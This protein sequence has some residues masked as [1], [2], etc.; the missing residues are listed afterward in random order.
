[1]G[2]R[3]DILSDLHIEFNGWKPFEERL[4]STGSKT[5][6][7]S[8]DLGPI[9]MTDTSYVFSYLSRIYDQI[10]YV[11]GN[12]DYYG[13]SISEGNTLLDE[14][15]DW[16]PGLEI[17]RPGKVSLIGNYKV[18]G[19]TLW[20]PFHSKMKEYPI[21]DPYQITDLY[22]YLDR[23]YK[24]TVKW[25]EETVDNQTI[26][27][28]HHLPHP[29]SVAAQYKGEQTNAWFVSD[30]SGLIED[31]KPFMWIHGH[32]HCKVDYMVGNTRII[33]NAYGYPSENRLDKFG[34]LTY[35]L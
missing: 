15:E 2:I 12:H 30:L 25:L 14:L 13:G 9:Y 31:K 27:V 22:H 21:N 11:P 17:L 24:D 23:M 33:N 10:I 28:T 18:V 19:G 34:T 20:V 3:V 7:C 5:L 1:M 16:V 32:S 8:G 29:R 4:R 35:Y 26:V 6:I